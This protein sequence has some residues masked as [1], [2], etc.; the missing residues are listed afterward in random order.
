L[1][2]QTE[3]LDQQVELAEAVQLQVLMDHQQQELVV[4]VVEHK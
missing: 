1:Q 3:Y 4:E 2:D